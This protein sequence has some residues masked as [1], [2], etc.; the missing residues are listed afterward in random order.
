MWLDLDR[1][2]LPLRLEVSRKGLITRRTQG[3][4]LE[5]FTLDDG[6]RVWFPVTGETR[7][8]SREEGEGKGDAYI[9]DVAHVIVNTVRFNKNLKDDVF[10]AERDIKLATGPEFQRMRKAFL[11]SRTPPGSEAK[12]DPDSVAARLAERLIEADLQ[13]KQLEASS[14]ARESW[15]WDTLL[16]VLIALVST[17]ALVTAVAVKLRGQKR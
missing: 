5:S 11:D 4:R 15:S 1:G 6:N 2:G 7:F 9:Q 12:S 8:Y 10:T 16:S 17:G 14:V 3:I 13:A